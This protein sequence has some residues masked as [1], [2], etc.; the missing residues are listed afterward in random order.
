M[1]TAAITR[2]AHRVAMAATALLAVGLVLLAVVLGYYAEW[3]QGRLGHA[4][5]SEKNNQQ[6]K[7]AA[8]AHQHY[9]AQLPQGYDLAQLRTS[10]EKIE[11]NMMALAARMGV[12]ALVL[13]GEGR[14]PET[15]LGSGYRQVLITMKGQVDDAQSLH[16]FLQQLSRPKGE[17]GWFF[18]Q[19]LAWQQGKNGLTFTLRGPVVFRP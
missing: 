2:T 14:S 4:M 8:L 1:A 5:M 6:E 18:A 7:A 12:R 9:V 19:H 15:S 17:A 10:A 16:Q 13:S 11:K 3:Q